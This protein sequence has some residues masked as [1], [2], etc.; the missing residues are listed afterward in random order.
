MTV[1]RQEAAELIIAGA[2]GHSRMR[3]VIFG[4]VTRDLLEAAPVCC[5]MSH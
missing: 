1:A 3:E 4:S 2:Y 5:M